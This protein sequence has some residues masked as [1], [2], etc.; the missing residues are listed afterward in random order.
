VAVVRLDPAPFPYEATAG[1]TY[2][3]LQAMRDDEPAGYDAGRWIAG[4]AKRARPRQLAT[5]S[6]SRSTAPR[7]A[8]PP[9]RKR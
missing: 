3:R 1:F 8:R 9:P 2:A 4:Q 7:S 5:F 6:C